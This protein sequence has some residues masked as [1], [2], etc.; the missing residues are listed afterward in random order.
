[1]DSLL[2]QD[3]PDLEILVRD[4][5]SN[6][7]TLDLLNEYASAHTNIRVVSGEN[8]GFA[9][10]F[11]NLLEMSSPTASYLALCDQDDVW[12]KD[13]V[14]RAVELLSHYP[15]DIPMLY[16]SRL[17]IVDKRLRF[18]SYTDLRRNEPSF[19]N[20]IVDC[21]QGLGCTI[22]LNQ[23]TRELL[24]ETPQEIYSHDWWIYLVASCFGNIIYDT[25]SRIL[26]RKHASNSLGV[27]SGLWDK[28]RIKIDRFRTGKL[29]RMVN[30]SVEFM[31]IYGSSIPSR[32]RQT[33]E[34]FIANGQ[35]KWLER[36]VY[37]L[38]S[39]IRHQSTLENMILKA[40][41]ALNRL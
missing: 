34:R 22:L 3:Y 14:S 16:G 37:A 10:S 7:A 26:H 24:Y 29:H 25:E 2:A 12:L 19:C 32:N 11:F 36:I 6:D 28:W 17:A 27:Y 31:R 20:A 8:L 30:Q 9:K 15:Q 4:D 38:S 21:P 35:R 13:K 39:E 5:G 33:L 1:M 18:L 23:K 41:I 40:L